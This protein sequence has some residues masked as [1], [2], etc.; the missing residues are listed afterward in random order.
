MKASL[1]FT[2][3]MTFA[4]G[5]AAIS[6]CAGSTGPVSPG[7]TNMPPPPPTPAARRLYVD[8]N[9]LLYEYALPLAPHSKPVRTLN[10]W[11]GLASAPR[12]AVDS[13]GNL[14][15]ASPTSIRIF[16]PPIVS[17]APSRAKLQI[18][19]T[20]AITEIGISGAVLADIEY[21]PNQNL[22]L[23]KKL[24]GEVSELRVPLSKSSVAA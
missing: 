10:E 17:L 20:P 4:L 24:G 12:I 19:L 15:L 9:G 2:I 21:D 22:W 6:G 16:A 18:T 1:Y 11:P 13:S 8:H 5:V 3:L 23:L 7:F 14:A